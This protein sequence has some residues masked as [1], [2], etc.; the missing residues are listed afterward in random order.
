M[1]PRHIYF[2]EYEGKNS[3]IPYMFDSIDL[4]TT[5]SHHVSIYAIIYYFLLT[6][7]CRPD[8]QGT[9]ESTSHLN[10]Y[11]KCQ[12]TLLTSY[13]NRLGLYQNSAYKQD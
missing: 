10:K 11:L 13:K 6:F 8:V 7:D 3:Q 12:H 5:I 9:S 2:S 4:Y 1:L